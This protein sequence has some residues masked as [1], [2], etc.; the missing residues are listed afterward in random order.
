MKNKIHAL[1]NKFTDQI[2]LDSEK[3]AIGDLKK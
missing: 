2:V 3:I 1:L